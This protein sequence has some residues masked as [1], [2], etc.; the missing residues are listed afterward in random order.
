MPVS[1]SVI[2]VLPGPPAVAC[3]IVT[4][5]SV[6]VA[7]TLPFAF[8]QVARFVA[9]SSLDPSPISNVGLFVSALV[10]SDACAVAVIVVPSVVVND[11]V[12]PA[13]RSAG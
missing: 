10:V 5:L 7:E 6:A 4:T 3:V 8:R 13:S 1:V 11:I 9:V 2:V 12:S